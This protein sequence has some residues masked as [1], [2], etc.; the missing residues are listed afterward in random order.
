MG[1]A[2][3]ACEPGL[4][5]MQ[6]TRAWSLSAS[7][8]PRGV[9]FRS[10]RGCLAAAGQQILSFLTK[11]PFLNVLSASGSQLR[12]SVY[13]RVHISKV[14]CVVIICRYVIIIQ[15]REKH[16]GKEE[17]KPRSKIIVLE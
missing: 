10:F 12:H 11:L 7:S 1:S 16:A 5:R 4:M 14:P 6:L 3:L 13:T 8:L 9:R 15:I 2:I 17:I